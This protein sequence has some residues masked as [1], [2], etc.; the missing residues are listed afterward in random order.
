VR[1]VRLHEEI[2]HGKVRECHMDRA[3]WVGQICRRLVTVYWDG[4]VAMNAVMLLW[5][6][7]RSLLRRDSLV[8]EI[9]LARVSADVATRPLCR[10]CLLVTASAVDNLLPCPAVVK[11]GGLW[12]PA[13]SVCAVG[14]EVSRLGSHHICHVDSPAFR[15]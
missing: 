3:E 15:V 13:R 8:E 10:F 14:F 9:F 2:V 1:L 6:L 5:S 4:L 11:L 12:G 7:F